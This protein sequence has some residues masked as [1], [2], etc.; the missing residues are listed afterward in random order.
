MAELLMKRLKPPQFQIIAHERTFFRIVDLVESLPRGRLLDIPAGEGAISHVLRPLGFEV[1]A[2]DIDP[3]F[4]KAEGI[5]CLHADMNREIPVE[6]ET[7]DYVVC[8]EGIEHL[9]SPFVFIR[10]CHRIL[11]QHGLLILSTPNILNLA[12]RLKFFFS[13]F[14][15][16]CPRPLDEFTHLPVFDHISPLTYYQLRYA[17]HSSGFQI[18]KATTD[19]WRRSC[20]PF[21]LFYPLLRLYSIRTMRKEGDTRQRKANREIRDVMNSPDMLLGRSL[22]LVAEKQGAS[23]LEVIDASQV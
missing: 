14:Y 13:G 2:A 21:L 11:R 3:A 8:L 9:Q 20:W 19:L 12:S 17:L 1:T 15:S 7:F 23:S 16:L 4:F 10:E 5:P 6:S 22:I 18:R